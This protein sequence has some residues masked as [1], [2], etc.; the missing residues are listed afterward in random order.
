MAKNP[1]KT[2]IVEKLD[3]IKNMIKSESWSTKHMAMEI[4]SL[5]QYINDNDISGDEVAPQTWQKHH[6]EG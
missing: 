2:Q 6:L 1:L 5:T 3:R 4:N